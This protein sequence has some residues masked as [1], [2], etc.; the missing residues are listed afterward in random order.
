MLAV[1]SRWRLSKFQVHN[2]R[3]YGPYFPLLYAEAT[4]N[5]TLLGW[6]WYPAV[7]SSL[8][9]FV[10]YLPLRG[11]LRLLGCAESTAAMISHSCG[12]IVWIY[13]IF[14][15]ALMKVLQIRHHEFCC[16]DKHRRWNAMP[17]A[18]TFPHHPGRRQEPFHDWNCLEGSEMGWWDVE[19]GG[20]CMP[21]TVV[22][23][24]CV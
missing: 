4:I 20:F 15:G 21:D 9:P 18:T 13:C 16:I 14:A 24:S 5:C 1:V 2:A 8:P 17:D 6:F 10:S 19:T 3:W 22:H 7:P 23:I 11:R 12:V